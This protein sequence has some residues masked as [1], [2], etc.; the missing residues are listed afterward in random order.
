MPD[1]WLFFAPGGPA[2]LGRAQQHKLCWRHD[3]HTRMRPAHCLHQHQARSFHIY[4]ARV[5]EKYQGVGTPPRSVPR[6]IRESSSTSIPKRAYQAH[7]DVQP[8]LEIWAQAC[9]TPPYKTLVPT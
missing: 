4:P 7:S 1:G 6:T 5:A 8:P 9:V 3:T 2:K